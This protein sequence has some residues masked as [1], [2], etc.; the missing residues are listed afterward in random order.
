MHTGKGRGSTEL[1]RD[2]EGA[3]GPQPGGGEVPGGGVGLHVESQCADRGFK[4]WTASDDEVIMDATGD[5][6]ATSWEEIA[7]RLP[8]CTILAVKSRARVR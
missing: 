7:H 5:G 4:K 8:G 1:E 2:R 6:M 3:A